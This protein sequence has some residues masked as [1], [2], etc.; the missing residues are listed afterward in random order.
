MKRL[1]LLFLFQF[2]LNVKSNSCNFNTIVN[3]SIDLAPY[4]GSSKLSYI[5]TIDSLIISQNPIS[6]YVDSS[7]CKFLK[8]HKNHI[9]LQNE[10]NYFEIKKL[11]IGSSEYT[12]DIADCNSLD[13]IDTL[14]EYMCLAKI[15]KDE[16][17]SKESEEENEEE[18]E[19][20]SEEENE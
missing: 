3:A 17:N 7:Y 1:L 10:N 19:E 2:A 18:S 6:F 9:G 12:G 8:K 16:S 5:Y 11:T 4:K 14:K 13:S 20:E 15:L